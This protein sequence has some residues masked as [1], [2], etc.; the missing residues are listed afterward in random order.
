M[1]ASPL[2][3]DERAVPIRHVVG[4]LDRL[5]RYEGLTERVVA[6]MIAEQEFVRRFVEATTEEEELQ[7][8]ES[9]VAKVSAVLDER[10][11]KLEAQLQRSEFERD[12]ATVTATTL[13][14]GLKEHDDLLR[15]QSARI[16]KQ[17]DE[18]QHLA[19]LARDLERQRD[20]AKGRAEEIGA[21]LGSIQSENR[22]LKRTVFAALLALTVGAL[23][24]AWPL[25]PTA[26]WKLAS[27]VLGGAILVLGGGW[28][29]DR[30]GIKKSGFWMAVLALLTAVATKVASVVP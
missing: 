15:D 4:A 7:L 21:D 18:I 20:T 5:Q 28:L 16:E 19:K 8:V 13:A 2:L 17:S 23:Y 30:D 26:G 10:I 22:A 14:D 27:G 1:V 25:L 9:K 12:R 3:A 6:G 11:S 24:F 29:W